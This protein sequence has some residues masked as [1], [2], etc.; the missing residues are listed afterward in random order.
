M[1]EVLFY[2]LT[3][4]VLER[5]L[6][7]L[8]TRALARGWKVVVRAGNDAQVAALDDLLWSFDQAS[9]LPHGTAALGHAADQP[10]YLTAG[11]E[12]PNAATVLMLVE[13]ARVPVAQV[14]GFDRVCLLFSGNDAAALEAARAD[15]RAVRDAGLAGK[16]WAE[17]AGRWTEKASTG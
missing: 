15:W 2:H 17:E 12:N 9:F 10:V 4:S 5:T 3:S 6:P 13:G 11:D 8:L 14:A 7:D 16:Y 1:G